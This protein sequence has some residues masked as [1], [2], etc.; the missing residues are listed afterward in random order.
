MKP[1]I[2]SL[3]SVRMRLLLN[4]MGGE[5]SIYRP[6]Y[7]CFATLHVYMRNRHD[8]NTLLFAEEKRKVLSESKFQRSVGSPV[9]SGHRSYSPPAH[10]LSCLILT[11]HMTIE[12][13]QHLF[14]SL[15]RTISC[16]STPHRAQ[17][18]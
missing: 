12:N 3:L 5:S 1:V 18:S 2:E 13:I 10:Q 17:I 15:D 14:L 7:P 8:Y 16:T 11:D 9:L 4:P 6:K